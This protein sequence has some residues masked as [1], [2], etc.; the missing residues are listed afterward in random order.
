MFHLIITIQVDF[1]HDAATLEECLGLQKGELAK[2]E[3]RVKEFIKTC[4]TDGV[5]PSIVLERI[6][7][8]FSYTELLLFSLNY[9]KGVSKK[10]SLPDNVEIIHMSFK[11][12]L[13]KFGNNND[14]KE[15][16]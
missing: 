4:K 13:G 15:E 1:N 2:T 14:N 7:Q 6:A 8:T 10:P 16:K 9:M 3:E 12:F 11:D 5:K